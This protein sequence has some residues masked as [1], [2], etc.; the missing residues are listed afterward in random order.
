MDNFEYANATD[1]ELEEWSCNVSD[2]KWEHEMRLLSWAEN[3][4]YA[5]GIPRPKMP[6]E[7]M[8]EKKLNKI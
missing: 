1:A 6:W 3:G 8:A 4:G 5:A 7:N 2:D